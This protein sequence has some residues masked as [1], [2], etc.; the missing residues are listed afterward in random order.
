MDTVHA[1]LLVFYMYVLCSISTFC[2]FQIPCFHFHITL[3]KQILKPEFREILNHFQNS[4]SFISEQVCFNSSF[5][6][7]QFSFSEIFKFRFNFQIS[8]CILT[9]RSAHGQA[10]PAPGG[11]YFSASR[12]VGDGVVKSRNPGSASASKPSS[13]L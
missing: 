4:M 10:E 5:R 6:N 7:L 8:Y 2:Y 12:G 13:D 11:L 3:F 9:P 1:I